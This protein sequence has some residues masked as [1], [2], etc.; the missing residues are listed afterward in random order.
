MTTQHSNKTLLTAF[1]NCINNDL[2]P[3][4]REGIQTGS[5]V[6]G[7]AILDR[8]TLKPLMTA[9]N[10]QY[11][12][13]LLHG[14]TNCIHEF[15]LKVP[16]E[17]RP[18]PKDCVFLAS[19]EPCSMCMSAITWTGFTE[20]YYLFTSEDSSEFEQPFDRD[21][22]REVFQTPVKG[23][24]EEDF[25]QRQ[26]YNRHNKYFD[27]Y[28][29]REVVDKLDDDNEKQEIEE[30]F[31]KIKAEYGSLVKTCQELNSTYQ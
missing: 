24:T 21:I 1:I 6:F 31:D 8:N 23:E 18:N 19:H 10:D 13:P 29:I 4:T 20:I 14:E 9:I 2:I 22:Y 15:Y 11:I 3:L 5:K 28:T 26:L 16:K 27:A 25:E 12:S 30:Q 7:G 17:Q